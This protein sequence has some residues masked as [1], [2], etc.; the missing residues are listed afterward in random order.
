MLRSYSSVLVS[1]ATEIISRDGEVLG[2]NELLFTKFPEGDNNKEWE[3]EFDTNGLYY[4]GKKV[5]FRV[6]A[7]EPYRILKK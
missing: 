3:W 2:T 6:R 7:T 1:D 4:T 5:I